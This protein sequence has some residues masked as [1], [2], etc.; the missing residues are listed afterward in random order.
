MGKENMLPDT[1]GL[2]LWF[3]TRAMSW[4]TGAWS[5]PTAAKSDIKVVLIVCVGVS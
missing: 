5:P 4:L 2:F 3:T 1:P